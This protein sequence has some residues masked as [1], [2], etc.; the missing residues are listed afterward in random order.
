MSVDSIPLPLPPTGKGV[1]TLFKQLRTV[2][3]PR[4]GNPLVGNTPVL[5]QS[6]HASLSTNCRRN[7]NFGWFVP[8]RLCWISRWEAWPKGAQGVMGRRKT[9]GRNSSSPSPLKLPLTALISLK[10][11][12]DW[13]TTGDESGTAAPD[14]DAGYRGPIDFD[15]C[16]F[17]IS[18]LTLL[19][20][21]FKNMHL[22][23]KPLHWTTALKSQE[24]LH[25]I[26]CKCVTAF[27]NSFVTSSLSACHQQNVTWQIRSNYTAVPITISTTMYVSYLF[28]EK[29]ISAFLRL[30]NV[31]C[32]ILNSRIE[33]VNLRASRKFI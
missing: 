10:L 1:E 32:P 9:K 25:P 5:R 8:T 23:S 31:T 19:E 26:F 15:S 29:N 3:F 21:D 18:N 17:I 11:I 30:A 13:E 12:V 20:L 24:T 28:T 33:L 16:S 4:R 6:R 7:R 14:C 27:C 2:F 22:T